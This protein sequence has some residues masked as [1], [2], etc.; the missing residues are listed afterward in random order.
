M[1][2]VKKIKDNINQSEDIPNLS[3]ANIISTEPLRTMF[4]VEERRSSPQNAAKLMMITDLEDN[5]TL[6]DGSHPKG[7][8]IDGVVEVLVSEQAL[9]NRNTVLGNNFILDLGED[10]LVVKPVG[11]FEP[12]SDDSPY[13]SLISDSYSQDFIV[14]EKWFRNVILEDYDEIIGIGRF[15][16]AFDYHEITNE[17]FSALLSLESKV[18]RFIKKTKEDSVLFNFPI[19]DI[20]KSY[21]SKELQLTT[22]LWALNVPVLF[23]L[24]IYLYMISRLIIERQLNEIAVFMSRGAGR[25]QIFLIYLI[26]IVLLGA[27]AFMLGPFIGL[28]LVKVLGRSEEHTSE[29]QSRG[30]LVCRLLL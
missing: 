29:L 30:H 5:I 12:K 14:N 10:Q 3:E 23:M 28:Q 26:E 1:R 25:I 4:E 27:V 24:A 17:D 21:E 18:K 9:L 8:E 19:K 11:T 7:E 20:L 13:W 15:S 16:T 22:M 6:V 2:K